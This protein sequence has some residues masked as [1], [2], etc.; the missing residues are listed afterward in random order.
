LDYDDNLIDCYLFSLEKKNSDEV[1]P[2]FERFV[3]IHSMITPTYT[4]NALK[5]TTTP[6]NRALR[7]AL[8]QLGLLKIHFILTQKMQQSGH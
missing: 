6:I 5:F 8:R 2:K 1:S 7:L 4:E 3:V